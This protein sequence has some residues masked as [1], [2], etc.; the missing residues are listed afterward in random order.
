MKED[1]QLAEPQTVETFGKKRG[2][3]VCINFSGLSS[4]MEI[5][6]NMDIYLG[7]HAYRRGPIFKL[8]FLKA[9]LESASIFHYKNLLR[10]STKKCQEP[11]KCLNKAL[12]DSLAQWY[13]ARTREN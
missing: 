8:N 4:N 13:K 6:T 7:V 10:A 2:F 11:K 9:G 12:I 3:A 5:W 1:L